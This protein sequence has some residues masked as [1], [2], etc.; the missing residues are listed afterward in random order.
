MPTQLA[1]GDVLRLADRSK[2]RVI[3]APLLL[4]YAFSSNTGSG[5]GGGGGSSSGSGNAPG[6]VAAAEV[7]DLP[8]AAWGPDITH[9]VVDA[10]GT[11]G[12][13]AASALLSGVHLVA[14]SWLAA[15]CSQK[16]WSGS[17]PSVEEHA[18]LRLLLEG[19]GGASFLDLQSWRPPP[20]DALSAWALAIPEQ[21]GVVARGQPSG[22]SKVPCNVAPCACCRDCGCAASAS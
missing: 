15:I 8:L 10:N 7:L 4:H 17:L 18:P 21:V 1:D 3:R 11:L 14:P 9:C 6:V 16:V 2:F 12:P 19:P 13:G 20:E 5:G 22:F